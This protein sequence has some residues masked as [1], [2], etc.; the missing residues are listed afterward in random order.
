LC[1]SL[2]CCLVNLEMELKKW[3]TELTILI[4]K[5]IGL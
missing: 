2:N 1:V 5:L 3:V 4:T